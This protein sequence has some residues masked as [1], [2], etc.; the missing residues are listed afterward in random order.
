[1]SPNAPLLGFWYPALLS[2]AVR[3]GQMKAQSLL[4]HPLV[5]CR[6]REGRVSALRD[7]CP[8]RAMPLSFGQFDGE[9]LECSY[10]GWQF[11]AMGRCRHIPALVPGSPIQREKISV[12]SYPCSEEDGYV[13]VYIPDP[14]DDATLPPVPKLPVLS[15]NYRLMHISAKL[16]CSVDDGIV[17]LMDPAHGPFVHHSSW[18]RPRSSIHEKAKVFEPIPLG[19]RMKA[20]EPS[21]N[22]G[23]YKVLGL[24]GAP[25][26]TTIDFA[27]PNLRHELVQAGRYWFSS[28]A[29]VT[30]ITE[31]ECRIDFCAAWNCFTWVPFSTS[32]FRVFARM[33]LNQDRD[34]MERQAQGLRYKPAMM[35]LDDA[36]TPAKWYYKLKAAYLASRRNGGSFEHPLKEPV[37]LR[38]RS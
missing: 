22:S 29:T 10:H 30:P 37:T 1:V 23:L 6:S 32:I 24:S 19:F 25:I 35:L 21:K 9:R 31:N 11:D 15:N 18:W 26:M 4:G 8:H 3:I 28:R 20:H 14:L 16:N 17:G 33:F 2:K 12:Q 13:W 7:I 27:L 34:I 5:I 36:D 38:W